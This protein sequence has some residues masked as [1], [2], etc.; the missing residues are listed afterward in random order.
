MRGIRVGRFSG[1]KQLS[2]RFLATFLSAFLLF[3]ASFPVS[4]EA[5]VNAGITA[6][7]SAGNFSASNEADSAYVNPINRFDD[8]AVSYYFVTQDPAKASWTTV[9]YQGT[10]YTLQA[11][12]VTDDVNAMKVN[13]NSIFTPDHTVFFD[14]GTYTDSDPYAYTRFS[15]TNLSL[16]G[17]YN[18]GNGDP[19]VVVTKSARPDNTV[20][21][22]NIGSKNVYFENLVFDGLG[23]NMTSAKSRGEYCFFI[24]GVAAPWEGTSGFVM[25]NCVIQNIGSSNT[26]TLSRNVAINIYSS[27]GQHNFDDLTIRNIKT[28]MGLG[29]VSM[30]RATNNFF[31]NLTIDGT[32]CH[33]TANSVKIEDT[34]NGS[35]ILYSTYKNVFAGSLSLTVTGNQ[36]YVYVERYQ[37]AKTYVPGA[38]RYARY[39]TSNGS[40]F[41]SA[42]NLYSTLPTTS[43]AFAV[44]DLSDNYWVVRTDVPTSVESQISAIRTIQSR[45]SDASVPA[46]VPGYMI[47]LVSGTSELGSFAVP[48][49]GNAP[50]SLVAVN[51]LSSGDPAAYD[52]TTL[53]PVSANATITLKSAVPS[54]IR[55]YNFDFDSLASYTL[56][57]AVLG[58][59]LLSPADPNE[60]AAP[61]GYPIYASYANASSPKVNGSTSETFINC[62]FRVLAATVTLDSPL[63]RI[64]LTQTTSFS[65]NITAGYTDISTDVEESFVSDTAIRWFSS[66]PSIISVDPVT[67]DATAHALG[68][69]TITAK[70]MDSWNDGEIEKP[71]A[72]FDIEVLRLYRVEYHGNGNESGTVPAP[73]EVIEGESAVISTANDLAREGYIFAG[74]NTKPDGT[75]TAY[76]VGIAL[77]VTGDVDLY[78]IWE[79]VNVLTPTPIPTATPTPTPISTPNPTGVP[80]QT[81]TPSIYPQPTETPS[82][83]SG[84]TTTPAVPTAVPTP[85][86]GVKG[87]NRK[88]PTTQGTKNGSTGSSVTKTGETETDEL[89]AVGIVFLAAAAGT[90]TVIVTLRRRVARR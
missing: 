50:A 25:N 34:D 79:K 15:V 4:A 12:V 5:T 8:G 10:T 62:S 72:T 80:T 58:I 41:A 31:R 47:K 24:T 19:T 14:T 75:G 7:A 32:Q 36:G 71:Y 68:T 74:W 40:S 46:S 11:T 76:S 70:A 84:V 1:M 44:L 22:Y 56:R 33:S 3:S 57:E 55:L 81:P 37:Y 27:N 64:G 17:L 53:L 49:L 67:G 60:T 13:G 23:R 51:L 38:F 82:P 78:A 39:S 16:I 6:S 28:T 73:T 2:R 18:D 45:V 65:A 69:A 83:G 21:R 26:A 54:Q 77:D 59:D 88:D 85:K 9:D 87:T 29:I 20:E 43:S 86:T 52:S 90:L 63:T 48:D 66:E 42:I 61:T 35:S 89:I 30:N